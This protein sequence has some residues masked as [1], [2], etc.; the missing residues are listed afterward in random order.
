MKADLDGTLLK[1][2]SRSFY[3]TIRALPGGLRQP[4]AL[5]YLLARASDTIADSTQTP[6]LARLENLRAFREMIEQGADAKRIATVREQIVPEEASEQVLIDRI[7]ECLTALA[8]SL[9][10]DREDIRQVLRT[11]LRGQK[12]DLVRFNSAEKTAALATAAE[13]DEYT[14]LVAGCV[15]E[16]WTRVCFRRLRRYARLDLETM[17]ILGRH[18]GQGLQLV[19]I[20]RDLPAD[21]RAGRC[22]LPADEL[23][24]AGVSSA[25]LLEFPE[26]ARPVVEHWIAR[27]EQ[28]LADAQTYIQALRSGRLRLACLLPWAI[29]VRTLALLRRNPPLE[30]AIRVKVSRAEVRAIL[31]RALFHALSRRNLAAWRDDLAR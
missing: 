16:F 8:T 3:L 9:E 20:L 26:K 31:R 23:R 22:Y 2:V 24:T 15:G 19:N 6:V 30:T 17:K 12:L 27:A 13:L 10:A 21:L 1:S 14:F 25:D 11:I 7:E 28:H 5:A 29:G 18:F 4:I